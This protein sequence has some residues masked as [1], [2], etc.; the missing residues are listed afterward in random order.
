MAWWAAL[1]L[2]VLLATHRPGGAGEAGGAPRAP[3]PSAGLPGGGGRFLGWHRA[4]LPGAE[5]FLRLFGKEVPDWGRGGD[6]FSGKGFAGGR[7]GG[8]GRGWVLGRCVSRVPLQ[9]SWKPTAT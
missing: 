5:M 4:A 9:P 6:V 7:D 3:L 2:G 1:L 8:S